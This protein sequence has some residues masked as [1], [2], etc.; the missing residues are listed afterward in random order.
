MIEVYIDNEQLEIPNTTSV[1]INVG[2]AHIE[3]PISASGSFSQTIDVPRTTHNEAVFGHTEQILSPDIFNHAEHT[4][5]VYEDGVELIKGKAYFEGA[6]DTHYKLQIVGNEFDWLERIKDKKLNEIDDTPISQFKEYETMTDAERKAVF[7]ALLNHG[8]WWQEVEDDTIRRKWATYA[9]LIPFV[10]LHTILQ[11]I[12][13]GYTINAGT[14]SEF[15]TRLYVTG[16]WK[17]ADNA[18]VLAE[19]NEWEISCTGANIID[20]TANGVTEAVVGT[21]VTADNHGNEAAYCDVFDTVESDPNNRIQVEEREVMADGEA[22]THN[23]LSFAPYVPTEDVVEVV[24]AYRMRLRYTTQ[25]VMR[26]NTPVFA[27]TI[28]FGGMPVAQLSFEDGIAFVETNKDGLNQTRFNWNITPAMPALTSLVSPL[29]DEYKKDFF[30]KVYEPDL[31]TE[32][33]QILYYREAY[34]MDVVVRYETIANSVTTDNY[35]RAAS[36]IGGGGYSSGAAYNTSARIALKTKYGDIVVVDDYYC[37]YKVPTYTVEYSTNDQEYLF[38]EYLRPC[39]NV[40]AFKYATVILYQFEGEVNTISFDVQLLT[41]AFNVSTLE[42]ASLAV[43]F[44]SSRA[45][46]LGDAELLV[47]VGDASLSPKFNGVL[48]FGLPISLNDVGGET[49]ATDMIKAIMHLFNLRIYT[50]ADTKVVH[51][52]PHNEFYTDNIVD[53]SNRIDRDKGI[54]IT[55]IGDDIGNA[56]LLTY[57]EAT[58]AI[59]YY[60]KR[61]NSPYL[62]WRTP[63]LSKRNNK[64]NELQNAAFTA[65]MTEPTIELFPQSP[66]GGGSLLNMVDKDTQDTLD[67]LDYGNIPQVLVQVMKSTEAPTEAI[68]YVGTTG[69]LA[70]YLQPDIVVT[71]QNVNTTISF[72]DNRGVEGL[73]KHYDKH[74]QAW[75]YGKRIICYCRVLPQEIE[76]LRKADTSVVD[77][78]SKFKLNIDGEDIYCRLESIENY[79]PQNATHKCT[80]I[81]FN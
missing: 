27:D 56:L 7:F 15:L 70:N 57:Q 5:A 29:P 39:R 47:A 74:V 53:W 65:P 8:C 78:R 60:N 36:H 16:Q 41:P 49:A 63:L 35:F 44:T 12:F 10:S 71:D 58:P 73:H 64:E 14:I 43:G 76:S 6:T 61:H 11:S 26:G 25:Y 45:T 21:K 9:D 68:Q 32:I 4:V 42:A 28:H 23:I 31:Y 54:E 24:T 19:D 59:E 3:D 69:V 1:G 22:I 2:I 50:N 40:E 62:S 51:L 80:F 77:F 34:S 79:E 33:V 17:M 66:M 81:Y 20:I 38:R 37:A 52:L 18:D 67:N 46:E 75:N 72:S 30:L 13:K 55:T 48:P